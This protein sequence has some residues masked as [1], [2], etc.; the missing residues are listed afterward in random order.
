M[1]K[2]GR[3]KKTVPVSSYRRAADAPPKEETVEDTVVQEKLTYSSNLE[4]PELPQSTP[5]IAKVEPKENDNFLVFQNTKEEIASMSEEFYNDVGA[6]LKSFYKRLI[7]ITEKHNVELL[8][9]TQF[10]INKN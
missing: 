2:R 6:E 10:R 3:P 5:V 7:V 9:S 1:A 8:C 4:V